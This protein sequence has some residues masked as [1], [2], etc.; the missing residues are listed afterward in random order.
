MTARRC[1]CPSSSSLR[2]ARC[3]ENRPAPFRTISRVI[4][5]TPSK[6]ATPLLRLTLP[7]SLAFNSTT[8]PNPAR[9]N[10]SAAILESDP[11]AAST[12][13][14][15]SL[16]RVAARSK[17]AHAFFGARENLEN[18]SSASLRQSTCFPLSVSLFS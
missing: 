5:G 3:L 16:N 13:R 15:I 12:T 4:R 8:L 11:L 14:V 10:V 9:R 18:N 7:S 2:M 17:G 1:S 6:S